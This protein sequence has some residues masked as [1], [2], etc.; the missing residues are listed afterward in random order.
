M[1][2]DVHQRAMIAYLVVPLALDSNIDRQKGRQADRGAPAQVSTAEGGNNVTWTVYHK[3]SM[4]GV[5]KQ[6]QQQ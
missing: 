5:P 3:Q 4:R 6:L 1:L 2:Q